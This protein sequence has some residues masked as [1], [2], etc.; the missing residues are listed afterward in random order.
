MLNLGSLYIDQGRFPNAEEAPQLLAGI[1]VG[2]KIDLRLEP[3]T[4]RIQAEFFNHRL[5]NGTLIEVTP[6]LGEKGLE[7]RCD[8]NLEGKY[9]QGHSLCN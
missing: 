9:L 4:G 6:L 2:G 7:W 5:P 8:G 1:A 3:D